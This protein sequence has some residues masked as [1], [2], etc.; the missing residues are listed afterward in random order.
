I[1]YRLHGTLVGT[2]WPL[3]ISIASTAV[4]L[5][6]FMTILF[7]RRRRNASVHWMATLPAMVGTILL[8]LPAEE[9]FF[10]LGGAIPVSAGLLLVLQ[11]SQSKVSRWIS[12]VFMF[13][14]YG[15]V[16]WSTSSGLVR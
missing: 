10:W 9:A 8:L 3:V 7:H 6:S 1:L 4:A 11:A 5:L 13:G 12:G 16:G 14:A 15:L 2:Q